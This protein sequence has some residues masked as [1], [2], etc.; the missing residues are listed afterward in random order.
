MSYFLHQIS[1]DTYDCKQEICILGANFWVII[2]ASKLNEQ[3]RVMNCEL[4]KQI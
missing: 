3:K 2:P 1:A 4:R